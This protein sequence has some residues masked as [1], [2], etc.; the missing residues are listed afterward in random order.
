MCYSMRVSEFIDKRRTC[1][2]STILNKISKI[3]VVSSFSG[4]CQLELAPRDD[5]TCLWKLRTK[6]CAFANKTGRGILTWW[7][8]HCF[9]ANHV[10]QGNSQIL[11]KNPNH[12]FSYN[13][14]TKLQKNHPHSLEFCPPGLKQTK[15]EKL[16]HIG[17][18]HAPHFPLSHHIGC[19]LCQPSNPWS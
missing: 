4:G 16:L 6:I 15:S 2:Y 1:Q 9:L 8:V 12:Q 5:R 11:P 18:E 17:E 10:T 13:H 7:K 3:I 19:I 14:I